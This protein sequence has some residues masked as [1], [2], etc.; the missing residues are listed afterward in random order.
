MY[1]LEYKELYIVQEAMVKNRT[2]QSY[3][4]KQAAMCSER[5]LLEEIRSRKKRPEEW[6]VVPQGDSCTSQ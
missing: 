3:R 6:R 1:V 2:C 4:W 5:G